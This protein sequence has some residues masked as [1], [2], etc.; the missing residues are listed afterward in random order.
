MMTERTQVAVRIDKKGRLTLPKNIREALGVETGA[1]LF[2]KYE[3]ESKQVR[4]APALSPFDVLAEQAIN[5]HQEGHT[6]TI[7]EFAREHNIRL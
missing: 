7:E 6:R 3:P 4:L 5:E 2:L 1:T